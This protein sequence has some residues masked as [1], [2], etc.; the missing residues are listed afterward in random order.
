LSQ[1]STSQGL[2]LAPILKR[3][4]AVLID[5]LILG[6]P[7]VILIMI[8]LVPV[9]MTAIQSGQEPDPAM[10]QA[11]MGTTAI[12]FLLIAAVLPVLYE[13]LMLA[14]NGQTLG[15]KWMNIRVVTPAGGKISGGQAWTRALVRVACVFILPTMLSA[16]CGLFAC[17]NPLLVIGYYVIG[18]VTKEKTAPHDMAAKTR[19]IT[20]DGGYVPPAQSLRP[21]PPPSRPAP[22]AGRPVPPPPAARPPQQ[23]MPEATVMLEFTGML[24]CTSGALEGQHFEIGD[25]VTIG[26]DARVAQIVVAD[27]RIS[28]KHAWVGKVNGVITVRDAGSTNGTFINALGT[29]ITEA[30]LKNGDTIILADDAIRFKYLG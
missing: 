16:M 11:A 12:A 1:Y 25:G 5:G 14:R 18:M 7:M 24:T 13:G 22:P 3:F 21:S 9:I 26:R 15:K 23:Q 17:L 4:L 30:P 10:I 28:S 2:P 19:V 27:S 6:I 8:P 29:R 20:L